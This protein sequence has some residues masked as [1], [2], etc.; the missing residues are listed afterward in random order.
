[1]IARATRLLACLAVGGAAITW[2]A[3]PSPAS[4]S[5]PSAARGKPEPSAATLKVGRQRVPLSSQ[6]L[7][8]YCAQVVAPFDIDVNAG[9]LMKLASGGAVSAFSDIFK[10]RKSDATQHKVSRD[11]REQAARMNWLPMSVEQRYG[12]YLHKQVVDNG[13]L[14]ERDSKSGKKLYPL[15]DALLADVLKGVKD[16]H[17]YTFDVYV[18][19]ESTD[20]A[21]A[22]PGGIVHLDAGILEDKKHPYAYFALAHEIGHVLQRHETRIAQARIIDTLSL[23]SS[24]QDL[25]TTVKDPSSISDQVLAAAAGGHKSFRKHYESQ[26]LQADACAVRILD[27]ALDSEA[28][29]V[30]SIKSF[31]ATLPPDA[32]TASAQPAKSGLEDL[33]ETANTPLDRHPTTKERT[34]NLQSM[35]R[36]AQRGP[37]R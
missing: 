23:T 17:P 16:S 35:L 33:L 5:V 37:P 1:M 12:R 30:L 24:V 20:N 3:E 36:V 28:M 15:A 6:E 2:A 13:E 34:Q 8:T 11:T 18:R 25:V 27:T 26:E 19:K 10:G 31:L 7:D 29:V 21:V 14:I 9:A 22:L 32:P 4:R